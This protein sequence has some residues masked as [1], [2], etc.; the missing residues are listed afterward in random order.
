MNFLHGMTK[1]DS[2]FLKT[3]YESTGKAEL[4]KI[5]CKHN[6]R[7]ETASSWKFNVW[8]NFSSTYSVIQN[9]CLTII[10][11]LLVFVVTF[12][13]TGRGSMVGQITDNEQI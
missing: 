6:L 3:L 8:K 1:S 9:Y 13:I 11:L 7:L 12:F 4:F 10:D 5:L 2:V